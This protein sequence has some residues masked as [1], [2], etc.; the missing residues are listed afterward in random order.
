M[1]KF[2]FIILPILLFILITIFP[3]KTA[4]A[5]TYPSSDCGTTCSTNGSIS[6]LCCICL[7]GSDTGK[8][9]GCY[10]ADIT[11]M[12]WSIVV[13]LLLTLVTI[14]FL[15]GVMNYVLHGGDKTKRAEGL[16]YIIWGLIGMFVMLSVWGLV[17]ILS[18]TFG[19]KN[20]PP[21]LPTFDVTP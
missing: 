14:I 3:V 6:A 21:T 9:L 16:K 13:P 5:T 18:A 10:A 2:I 12:L 20:K 1:K 17:G 19:L 15:Y 8:T 11:R 7:A 4:L